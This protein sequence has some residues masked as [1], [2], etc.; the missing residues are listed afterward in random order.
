MERCDRSIGPFIES[1]IIIIIVLA[2][3]V[4]DAGD[5]VEVMVV[6]VSVVT[7]FEL[8]FDLSI[9][10]A[11][12][13]RNRLLLILVVKIGGRGFVESMIPF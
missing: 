10:G 7:I 4:D 8:V 9:F 1:A 12:I 2:N 5:D 6:D 3:V 13:D 11:L